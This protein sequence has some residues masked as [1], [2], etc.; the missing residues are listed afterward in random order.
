MFVNRMFLVEPFTTKRDRDFFALKYIPV[1]LVCYT[2]HV[3]NLVSRKPF[4]HGWKH[5]S[6]IQSTG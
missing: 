6:V 1:M 2:D 3:I 4:S 5:K